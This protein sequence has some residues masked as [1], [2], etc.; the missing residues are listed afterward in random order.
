MASKKAKRPDSSDGDLDRIVQMI[1][2]DAPA[3]PANQCALPQCKS[4]LSLI[5]SKP[6][7][8]CN[9]QFCP[10][11]RLPEAHSETCTKKLREHS[12]STFRSDALRHIELS[13]QDPIATNRL[14]SA[15]KEKE[16]LRRR[17]KSKIQVARKSAGRERQE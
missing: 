3:R 1:E 8:F 4:K 11:H 17:L 6:C 13:K 12:R 15:A 14:G 9:R 16:E 2:S 5:A 10:P 7:E